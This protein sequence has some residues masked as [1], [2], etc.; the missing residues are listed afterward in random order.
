MSELSPQTRALLLRGRTY[1]GL[2][3][4]VRVRM[5]GA[6]VARTA[7][8]SALAATVAGSGAA[9]AWKV[10]AITA[11]AVALGGAGV[12]A[13]RAPRHSHPVQG[14]SQPAAAVDAVGAVAKAPATGETTADPGRASAPEAPHRTASE[15][16]RKDVDR[17][18]DAPRM[19]R[20]REA[21]IAETRSR[22]PTPPTDAELAVPSQ[23][24]ESSP[25]AAAAAPTAPRVS[26][27][28]EEAR[29]LRDAHRALAAGDPS[30]ALALLDEDARRF[31]RGALE[32]ERAAERVFALCATGDVD[33]A[34][35]E[36]QAFV[37]LHAPGALANRVAEGCGGPR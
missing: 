22:P 1:D 32:P 4:E 12:V 29:L 34:T 19:R 37:R 27:L 20:V 3:Q 5:K 25:P 36:A 2:S 23:A 31:P 26:P 18:D 17:R 11:V 10:V 24:P 30:R 35:R 7:G 33:R 28:E 9:L 6:L 14:T 15:G 13:G 21:A 16:P 8:A